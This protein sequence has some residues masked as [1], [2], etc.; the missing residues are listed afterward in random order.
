MRDTPDKRND[1]RS[2]S[3]KV[4]KSVIKLYRSV[5]RMIALVFKKADDKAH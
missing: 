2:G 5:E 3:L 1:K 4:R